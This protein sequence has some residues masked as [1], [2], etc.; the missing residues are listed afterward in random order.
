MTVMSGQ[1]KQGEKLQY[2]GVK[3]GPNSGY[4]VGGKAAPTS[5]HGSYEV[6][7]RGVPPR[8]NGGYEVGGSRSVSYGTRDEV[9][10]VEAWPELAGEDGRRL[11]EKAPCNDE[12]VELLAPKQKD[13]VASSSGQKQKQNKKK[14]GKKGGKQVVMRLGCG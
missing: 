9:N 13:E 12:E 4:E 5:F 10:H 1:K 8:F 2:D 7:G 3:V 11:S 6:G 14:Q